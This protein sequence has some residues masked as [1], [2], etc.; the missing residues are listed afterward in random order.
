M[1]TPSIVPLTLFFIAVAVCFWRAP[2]AGR[3][4]LLLCV[5]AG[6]IWSVLPIFEPSMRTSSY[7]LVVATFL[8]CGLRVA[9][10]S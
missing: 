7:V 5:I 9:R 1:P 10:I 2:Q 4:H 3:T 8:L 6:A